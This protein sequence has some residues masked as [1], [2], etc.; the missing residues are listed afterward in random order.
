VYYIIADLK[1]ANIYLS[2]NEDI[3]IGDFGLGKYCPNELELFAT[4]VLGSPYYM[5]PERLLQQKY[6]LNCDV[7]SLGC[8]IY[9]VRE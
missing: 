8:V 5:S 9:E 6:Y 4:T 2:K 1:P 3:K 7:W